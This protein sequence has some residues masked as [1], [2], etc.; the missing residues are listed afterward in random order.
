MSLVDTDWLESNINEV[1][2]IDCSWHMPAEN[3]NAEEEFKNEHIQNAIFFDLDKNSK[4][5]TDLPHMLPTL[6]EWNKIVSNLGISKDDQII[7][8]DNSNVISSCRCWY[9]FI[10]FGHDPRLV[11]VLNGGLKKWKK[12]NKKIC[13]KIVKF[14]KTNY[15]GI[16]L[17]SLVKDKYK[18]DLNISEKEFVVV[19]ARSKERFEGKLPDPRKNVRSGS[20]PNSICLP[21]VEVINKDFSFKNVEELKNLFKN[22][23]RN[24]TDKP[25]FSCGS[26]VTACV[27]ALAYSLVNANYLPVIYDGSWA[28][29]GKI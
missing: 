23:F 4:N 10:Y 28:E 21:F 5:N 14:S 20:I 16:E 12:E 15:E 22:T 9:N 11:S 13:N 19:D 2:V 8:Y 17:I 7:I 27:L 26:G 25:V 24:P 6:D 18:I 1:K 29:Y 3:R